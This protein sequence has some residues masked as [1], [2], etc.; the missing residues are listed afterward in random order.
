MVWISHWLEYPYKL[1]FHTY[2]CVTRTDTVSGNRQQM[3]TMG[4]RMSDSIRADA[5]AVCGPVTVGPCSDSKR[6][7]IRIGQ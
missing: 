2:G 1:G 6:I 7:R 5:V 3:A 4:T